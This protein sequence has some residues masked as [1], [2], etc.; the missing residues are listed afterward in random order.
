MD[1]KKVMFNQYIGFHEKYS[2]QY[3]PETVVLIQSGS[4]FNIF[5]MINDEQ[6]IGPDIYHIGN[7]IL[8]ISVTRQNKKI[9]E[10]SMNNHLLAGF[11]VASIQKYETILLN[12]NY[13]V[14]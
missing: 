3:G 11:P 7:N 9:Q 12:H 14:Q 2:K 4:H 13:T 1:E 6:T 5:A 10:V 8:N